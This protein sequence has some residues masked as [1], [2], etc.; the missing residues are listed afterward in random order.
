MLVVSVL[1]ASIG[2]GDPLRPADIAGTY[3]LERVGDDPLPA[4]VQSRSTFQIVAIADTIHL[5]RDG[6]GTRTTI[7]V[8]LLPDGETYP[9]FRTAVGVRFEII[10]GKV[11]IFSQFTC[12]SNANCA[13]PAPLVVSRVAGGLRS[14]RESLDKPVLFFARVEDAD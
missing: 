14:V 8:M 1:A 11:R 5:R 13:L 10:R 6:S 3:V 2:C 12:P 4:V 9:A 7:T